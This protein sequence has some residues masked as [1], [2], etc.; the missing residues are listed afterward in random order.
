MSESEEGTQAAASGC[1]LVLWNR[2]PG[3]ALVIAGPYSLILMTVRIAL[4]LAFLCLLKF[5]FI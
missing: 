1:G 4:F 5:L 2:V 3:V